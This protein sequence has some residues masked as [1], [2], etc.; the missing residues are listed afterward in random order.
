MLIRGK[1]ME[2]MVLLKALEGVRCIWIFPVQMMKIR[3]CI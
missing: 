3:E 1:F 2:N